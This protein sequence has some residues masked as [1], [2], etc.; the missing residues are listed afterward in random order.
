LTVDSILIRSA[1]IP[2]IL[3]RIITPKDPVIQAVLLVT[4]DGEL[5]GSIGSLLSTTNTPTTTTDTNNT[6]TTNHHHPLNMD[7]FGALIADIAVDYQQLGDVLNQS[8]NNNNNNRSNN[9]NININS[10]NN[11]HNS[12]NSSNNNSNTSSSSSPPPTSSSSSAT[13]SNKKSTTLLL[14]LDQGL[15]GVSS[16]MDC[17]IIAIAAT[18]NAPMGMIQARLQAITE[19]VQE[20]LSPLTE[21]AVDR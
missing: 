15:V 1:R 3:S 20:G 5:L 12:H 10:N 21:T 4:A 13:K 18:P 16:C 19:H 9:N 6:N 17:W 14:E 7:D 8:N 11:S 2:D